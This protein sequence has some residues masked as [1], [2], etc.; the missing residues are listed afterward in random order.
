MITK[1]AEKQMFEG[2]QVIDEEEEQEEE[3]EKRKNRK[4]IYKL[5]N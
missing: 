1:P 5:F 2:E 3:A 4:K